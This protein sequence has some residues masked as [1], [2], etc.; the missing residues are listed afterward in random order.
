MD[1]NEFAFN[2]HMR[3]LVSIYQ[4][5][6]V[7]NLVDKHGKS[8]AVR[9]QAQLGVAFGKY[10]KRFNAMCKSHE[11]ED[12]VS[13][14]WFDFHHECRKLQWHNLSKLMAEIEPQLEDQETFQMTAQGQVLSTQKGVFRTN[15]MDNLDRTNVVQSLIGRRS[16]LRAITGLDVPRHQ[17]LDSPY[18][19]FEHVF[20]NLWADNADAVSRVYAGTG[21]LKT[22][23]TR[24]GTRTFKGKLMD[25]LNSVVRYGLNNFHDGIRQDALDLGTCLGRNM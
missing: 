2:A 24:T 12:M 1:W 22:D 3:E 5:V 18:V 19:T 25:G 11:E 10:C 17:V 8:T 14:V 9:D 13:Y 21:A 7:I 4:K 20:K 15:C 16:L 23:F 6:T